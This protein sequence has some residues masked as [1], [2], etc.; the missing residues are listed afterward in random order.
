MEAHVLGVVKDAEQVGLDGVWVA[1]LT[2]NLQQ[3]RVRHEEE[4]RE[5]QTFLLQVP[6]SNGN[7]LY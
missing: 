7:R 1:G 4:P 5:G 6:V 3:G 2:Q